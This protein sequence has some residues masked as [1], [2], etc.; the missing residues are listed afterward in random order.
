MQVQPNQ[1]ILFKNRLLAGLP[2]AEYQSLVDKFEM[3]EL[4]VNDVLCNAGDEINYVYFP[5]QSIISLM[6]HIDACKTLEVGMI[7]NE[8][9]LGSTLLLGTSLAPF[10]AIV[11][12]S[13]AALR[14]SAI[15]FTHEFKTSATLEQQLKRYIYV[16]LSQQMQN[17]ACNR[18]HIVE[19]RLARLL[20]MI[21]DRAQSENFQVTQESLAQMLGV[22]RV[23]VTMAAGALQN[24]NLI[25]YSR[26]DL[27]I[28]DHAGL[29]SASCICYQK[30]NEIYACVFD[31]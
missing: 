3:T 29:E 21:G 9:M 15:N 20:L 8:G 30:D 24:K 25:R 4:K 31:H 26:G 18:F 7:G 19:E 6:K 22:R 5:K 16:S 13:G 1:S 23:G 17:A 28:Q 11:Q 12:K 14:M 27:K 10:R 2:T